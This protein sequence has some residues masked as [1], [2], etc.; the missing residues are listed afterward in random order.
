MSPSPSRNGG[1]VE[2]IHLTEQ[3]A[4]SRFTDLF[5]AL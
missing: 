1:V 3:S 2:T 4:P 5:V